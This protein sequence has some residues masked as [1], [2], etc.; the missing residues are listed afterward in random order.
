MKILRVVIKFFLPHGF[1]VC[2]NSFRELRRLGISF[3]QALFASMT[4][5]RR[6]DL[7]SGRLAL[8]PDGLL[9]S[10]DC[11][12]DVGA[13]EGA[14]SRTVLSFA[15]PKSLFAIEPSPALKNKLT[16]SL[17]NVS[18]SKIFNIAVGEKKSEALFYMTEHS[19]NASLLKPLSRS[20]NEIYSYGY[21]VKS[22]S[23]VLVET[24]DGILEDVPEI[25]I[26]KI[27]T[28]GTELSV[29]KGAAETL[30]KTKVV[31]LEANFIPHYEGCSTFF[32]IHDFML[33]S[34]F[35]LR[36]LS[37]PYSQKQQALWSD[38]VYVPV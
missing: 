19:H 14:W 13:N 30:K 31:L 6:R 10:L 8:M 23:S 12:V 27:D 5:N 36:A 4:P 34:G 3:S 18:G 20:M 32:D 29:L 22:E 17:E 24:L 38:A 26:L 2:W 33:A 16:K 9:Q 35:K 7:E 21:D 1:V 15:Q 28:Q 25:T 11:V 37:V